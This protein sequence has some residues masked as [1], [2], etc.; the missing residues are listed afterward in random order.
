M[1]NLLRA[2]L[3]QT[4]RTVQRYAAL[5]ERLA[6]AERGLESRGV[7]VLL[8]ETEAEPGR[9]AAASEE[10]ALALFGE[11]AA[12][13]PGVLPEPL[14]R[15]L[16]APGPGDGTGLR[17]PAVLE[18]NDGVSVA[19]HLLPARG[20]DVHDCLLVEPI[21]EMLSLPT[22]RAAGLTAREAQIMRLVARGWMNSDIAAD[23]GVSHRTIQK[24]LQN[25]YEKLGAGSRMQAV[26]VAWSIS[27][28]GAALP[29]MKT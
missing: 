14:R 29:V 1:L 8:L 7:E 18:R 22:L 13:E 12:R 20:R 27:R 24:H 23:L 10:A 19:V 9:V 2:P 4:L 16:S 25:A 11:E 5:S 6:A 28:P 3:I 17:P 26:S 15:W 21:E